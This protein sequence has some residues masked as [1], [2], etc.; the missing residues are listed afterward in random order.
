MKLI[1][2]EGGRQRTHAR[3]RRAVQ[4]T[5]ASA[6]ASRV[7]SH[8]ETQDDPIWVA[9]VVHEAKIVSMQGVRSAEK[10]VGR[11]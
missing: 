2:F 11:H 8:G 5:F 4:L 3:D 10:A 7:D 1:A 9:Q 6:A